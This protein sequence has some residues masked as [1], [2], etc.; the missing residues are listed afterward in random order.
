MNSPRRRW[1]AILWPAFLMAAVLEVLVFAFVDPG[2]LHWIGG[3]P[4]EVGATTVYSLAFFGFWAV[5][6]AACAMTERLAESDID[7]NSR[8]FR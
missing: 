4:V 3:A 6:T 5:I 2:S 7:V 8:S 1:M